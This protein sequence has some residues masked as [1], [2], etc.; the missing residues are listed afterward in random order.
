MGQAHLSKEE[1]GELLYQRVHVVTTSQ[2][3]RHST[4]NSVKL[5]SDYLGEEIPLCRST[6][7]W[8]HHI[9]RLDQQYDKAFTKDHIFG[10]D[11]IDRI[12]KRV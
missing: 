9:D 5:A 10:V 1:A 4:K 2:E 8:P 11:L 7:T 3:L 6:A 12:H